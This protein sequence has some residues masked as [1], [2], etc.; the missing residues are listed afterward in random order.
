[1]PPGIRPTFRRAGIGQRGRQGFQG[2]VGTQGLGGP[3]VG[4]CQTISLSDAEQKQ[5][6]VG[7]GLSEVLYEWQVNFEPF[8]DFAIPFPWAVYV[9]VFMRSINNHSGGFK[10]VTG[11]TNPGSTSGASVALCDQ[12]FPLSSTEA[13][14]E[15]Y[16]RIFDLPPTGIVQ[17]LGVSSAANG[18]PADGTVLRGVTVTI[19]CDDPDATRT[20]TTPQCCIFP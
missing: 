4:S 6:T 15:A 8:V 13:P 10:L 7:S 18:G 12:P 16:G 17:L 3:S 1:M 20:C 9:G 5:T 2:L 19:T 14:Y 11:A